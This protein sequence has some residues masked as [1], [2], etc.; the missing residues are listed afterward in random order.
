MKQSLELARLTCALLLFLLS[1]MAQA[2]EQPNIVV[3]LAD[4]LG[5]GDMSLYDGWVKTP[6]IDQMASEGMKF[7][8]FHTNSSVCSPTRTAFLTGRYQQRYGIVD[9]I[10]GSKDQRGLSP[11][12]TTIPRV[13]KD[14][15]YETAIFGKW[16]LGHDD[17]Y[18]PIHHGFDEFTGFLTGGSD[19]HIH[20]NWRV[21][22]E[23]KNVPGYTTDIITEKSVDFIRRK[24]DKPFL[25]YVSHAAVHNPYQAPSD[26]PETRE[27]R[28]WNRINE[29][30][31]ERYKIIL[32]GLDE[33]VGKVLDTLAELELDEN[34]L[35]FFFSD[36]GA[37]H[38]NP[39]PESRPYRGGKFSQYEGGHRVPAVAW[40]PG[41]IKAGSTSDALIVGMDL[42]PTFIDIAG[43]SGD[44]PA[45]L[46]GTSAKSH[47]LDQK[48]FP[49]R[50][51]FFGYEPK[52]GT[53]MR[54]ENWKLIEND[55]EIQ[56]FD[57]G[58]DL[59]ETTNIADDHPEVVKEM[60]EAVGKF[61]TTVTEG[62]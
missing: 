34:T 2:K 3:I 28:K 5:C 9:V 21:G 26:I 8:D 4:D 37:V 53:A 15:G 46:D 13:F 32:E 25:L 50:D 43:L 12:V 59:K 17:K 45:N 18:N 20:N 56:L 52:L 36:N 33:S 14:N 23:K 10:V 35:V 7:N 61:K 27:D 55:G 6:R 58:K 30:N 16:H 47:L 11:S 24:K 38:M 62:S 60:L 54:R 42:F 29:G 57:L 1:G 31:R 41:K 40:W 51:I 39:Q 19:Y 44:N 49:Q 48:A 22:L